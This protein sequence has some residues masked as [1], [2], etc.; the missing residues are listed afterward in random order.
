MV[1]ELLFIAVVLA[2]LGTL[3]YAA[4]QALRGRYRQSGR[5][6]AK[7]LLCLAIYIGVVILVSL[8]SGQRV[9][10]IAETRC[11]DDW[12]VAVADVAE[13]P[14]TGGSEYTVRF[15]LSSRARRVI[16][17]E[18]GVVVYVMDGGGRRYSAEP[19]AAA[20][21]FDVALQPGQVVTVSRRFRVLGQKGQLGI[22]VGREGS[23]SIPGRFIIGDEDSL[24]HR[25]TIVHIP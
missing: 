4:V 1:F 20:V 5:L 19:D 18:H 2:S 6:V 3:G 14:L 10:Q 23:N 17:R 24:F 11:S 8:S 22:V 25:P 21:P 7:Y 12:C 9:L 16:Q 13:S 15:Q